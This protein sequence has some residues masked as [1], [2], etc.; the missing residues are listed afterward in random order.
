MHNFY[1]QYIQTSLWNYWTQVCLVISDLQWFASISSSS[2]LSGSSPSLQSNLASP[3]QISSISS[4][5]TR[6][7]SL[8]NLPATAC[9]EI[10]TASQHMLQM[11][12]PALG[13]AFLQDWNRV[14]NVTSRSLP[15]CTNSTVQQQTCSQFHQSQ[16][17]SFHSIDTSA[18]L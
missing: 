9:A 16:F 13:P 11:L 14:A 1:F 18:V 5:I 12:S 7:G 17:C 6:A 4:K 10:L 8:T 3:F 2:I 15:S